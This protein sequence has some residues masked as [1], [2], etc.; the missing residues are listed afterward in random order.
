MFQIREKKERKKEKDF[1]VLH[2]NKMFSV[3]VS[4]TIISQFLRIIINIFKKFQ[5]ICFL[6][7]KSS[8]NYLFRNKRIYT[9]RTHNY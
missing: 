5:I 1:K 6:S 8:G 3:S 9:E 7:S 2:C 4:S